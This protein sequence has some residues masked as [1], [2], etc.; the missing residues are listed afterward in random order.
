MKNLSK[1]ELYW[2]DNP[3]DKI[4]ETPTERRKK[5]F[6]SASLHSIL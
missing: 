2:P 1:N 6:I 3:I 5:T 4:S